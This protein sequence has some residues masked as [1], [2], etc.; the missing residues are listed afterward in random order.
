MSFAPDTHAEQNVAI[1]ALYASDWYYHGT[2]ET[3][4][5]GAIGL[6]LQWSSD[7]WFAGIEGHQADEDGVES[8]QRQRAVMVYAGRR[9]VL[10]SLWHGSLSVSQREFPGS[11]KE[12]DYTEVQLVAAHRNGFQARLDY[13]PDYY[14]HDAA[15]LGL[16]L[17][18]LR[19][20]GERAYGYVE[21][22]ALTLEERTRWQGHE[23]ASAGVGLN[24]RSINGDLS[25]R[26]NSEGQSNNFGREDYS[27]SQ[28]VLELAWRVR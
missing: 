27:P 22:G 4:G 24:W 28:F 20:L 25:Y 9:F 12:W 7:A 23:F 17:R 14:E 3:L 13:S 15:S 5:R 19:P 8:R 26:W 2:S 21:A 6:N 11:T 16:T 18:W 10:S 1:T